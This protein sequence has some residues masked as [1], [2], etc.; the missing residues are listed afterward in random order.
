MTI[1]T[2]NIEDLVSGL[3]VASLMTKDSRIV[4]M[5][6]EAIYVS[7]PVNFGE[8]TVIHKV[9][10]QRSKIVPLADTKIEGNVN[11]QFSMDEYGNVLRVATSNVL[12]GTNYVYTLDYNLKELD[13]SSSFADFK[14]IFAV[15][16][17]TNRLYISTF[18]RTDPFYVID[19]SNPNSIK[20]LG[21]LVLEGFSRFLYVFVDNI[22]LSFGRANG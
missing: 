19:V 8:E 2:F 9:F 21:N 15:R 1:F 6:E 20:I 17:T 18:Q 13:K 16:F 14:R 5:S 11:N 4:Y 10:V 22:I 3:G 7:Y 12:F